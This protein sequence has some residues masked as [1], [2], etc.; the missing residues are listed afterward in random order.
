MDVLVFGGSFDPPH[1][2]HARL[3]SA[4]LKTLRPARAYV[5][6]AWR[7]PLKGPARVPARERLALAELALIRTLP[8]ALRRKASLSSMEA[9]RA[10]P[11]F[12]YETLRRLKARHPG[13]ALHF[14]AGSDA[15][16]RFREWRRPAEV[17]RLCR[18]LVGRRPGSA[19][20]RP[21]RTLPAFSVLPGIFPDL[22]STGL[23]ARLAAGE[24]PAGLAPAVMRVIRARALY[25]GAL[26][27]RLR[28]SL[29]PERFGHTLAVARLAVELASAWGLDPEKAALAGLLHDCG[30]AV[31][32]PRMPA[33][34]RR[35]R[36]RVPGARE[37]VQRQPLLLHAHI[38]EDL[39]RRR[40]GAGDP[41]VL[42]AVRKHTLG[43]PRM[44]PLDRLLYVADACS[45]DRSFPEAPR[46]RR[47]ARRSPAE[48][49]REA[50]RLK[51]FH[52]LKGDGW[53]HPYASAVWNLAVED[54]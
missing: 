33:Y 42:S 50:A 28:E 36:L 30:R 48:S 22:S 26:R 52:V 3:F 31:P 6:P 23:R 7:S 19:L 38:S 24:E 47:L 27:A 29:P 40:H 43:A 2:G 10:R 37:I 51:L 41:E 32:V 17:R 11:S 13:A 16:A 49:F 45:A 21:D 18:F 46:I 53:L 9:A 8:A 54:A 12:T 39:A 1:E 25:G 20:P 34:V 4:A 44:S 35:R 15:L 5:V 14:L